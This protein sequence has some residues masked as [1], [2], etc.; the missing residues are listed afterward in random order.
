MHL[1]ATDLAAVAALRVDLGDAVHIV[2]A[3]HAPEL[4][5]LLVHQRGWTP[6]RYEHFFLADTWRRLLAPP[7]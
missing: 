1:F 3:T 6:E 2:W 5:Q 7:G 4:Y